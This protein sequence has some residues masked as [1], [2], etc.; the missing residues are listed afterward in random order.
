VPQQHVFAMCHFI[1]YFCNNNSC[2]V[3]FNYS[4]SES[5]TENK[6]FISGHIPLV[7]LVG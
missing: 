3:F 6:K 1:Q 5:H 4:G 2:W 7:T